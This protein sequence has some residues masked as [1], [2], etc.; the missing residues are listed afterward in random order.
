MNA[1]TCTTGTLADILDCSHDLCVALLTPPS[2]R[3]EYV[4]KHGIRYARGNS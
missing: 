1:H 2:G 3:V 4:G